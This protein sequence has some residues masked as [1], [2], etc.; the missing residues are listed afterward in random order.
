LG[1]FDADG[2]AAQH[3]Q[4][5]RELLGLDGFAVRP[6][7]DPVEP[8][9]GRRRRLG[10][11]RQ[12]DSAPR[13]DR[14][15]AVDGDASRAVEAGGAT[16]EPPPLAFEALD[17]DAV[18]PVVGRLVANAR[19]YRRPIRGD[20]RTS[21]EAIDAARFGERVGGADH[22][23]ARHAAPVR[24]LAADQPVIDA[25]HGEPGLGETPRHLLATHAQPDD[26]D[27]GLIGHGALHVVLVGHRRP[28]A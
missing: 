4:R 28:V 25:E 14:A 9:D 2:A 8:R 17:R 1:Q 16:H 27:I 20:A 15:Q 21:D 19:R 11:G 12:R 13:L 5:R 3:E 18:V 6:V 7:V 26:D 23:L 22:H 10:A 24:A